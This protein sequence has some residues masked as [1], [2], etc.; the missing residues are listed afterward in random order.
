MATL[1]IRQL[2]DGVYASL[3]RDAKVN[4][5]SIEAEARY[6]LEH[7]GSAA[8]VPGGLANRFRKTMIDPGP[9]Y[10]GSVALVRAIRDEE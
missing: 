9:D 6:R 1:T 2:D 7:G 10:E 4:H 3:K 5:R 8:I